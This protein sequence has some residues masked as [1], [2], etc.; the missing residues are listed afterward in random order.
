MV[1]LFDRLFG[2]GGKV[3]RPETRLSEDDATR[4]AHQAAAASPLAAMLILR[5]VWVSEGRL[6][7]HFW[8]PTRGSGLTVM[9]YDL[10]GD[11]QVHERFGR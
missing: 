10:S 2:R 9:V 6:A 3:E 8:T 7:W 11:V 5:G 4:L 1:G